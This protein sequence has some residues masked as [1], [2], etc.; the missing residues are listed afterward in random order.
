MI[1]ER[2]EQSLKDQELK[3][4][5]IER[6][7]KEI[8]DYNHGA[9]KIK[10]MK[11]QGEYEENEKIAHYL[12]EKAR[13]EEFD[14]QEKKKIKDENELKIQKLREIQGKT[15]DKQAILHSLRAKRAFEE[16]ERQYRDNELKEAEI[17]KKKIED[18]LKFNEKQRFDKELKI[19]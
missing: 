19:S 3:M 14:F 4:K 9:I 8:E 6:I 16:S 5:E 18:F 13:K 10:H 11:K 12:K 2:E 1:K 7:Q 17:K 15:Q